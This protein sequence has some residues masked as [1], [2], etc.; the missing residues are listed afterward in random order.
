MDEE[1][2]GPPML[3]SSE[4]VVDPAA[5]LNAETGDVQMTKVPISI[6]TGE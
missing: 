6:I 2:D 4:N 3:V 1:D 5:S